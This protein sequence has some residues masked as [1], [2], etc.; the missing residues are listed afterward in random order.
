MVNY[1]MVNGLL[2]NR[3]YSKPQAKLYGK[4]R[5]KLNSDRYDG[6]YLVE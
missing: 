6:L 1:R 5:S 4:L 2:Y 3:V